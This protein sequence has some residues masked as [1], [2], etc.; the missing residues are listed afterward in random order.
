MTLPPDP[1]SAAPGDASTTNTSAIIAFVL[2]LLG[3]VLTPIVDIAAVIL[4]HHALASVRRTGQP[5]ASLAKAALVIGYTLI[6]T[7][8]AVAAFFVSMIAGSVAA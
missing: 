1:A 5:G 8:V 2:S 7:G 6:V 3:I 4:G